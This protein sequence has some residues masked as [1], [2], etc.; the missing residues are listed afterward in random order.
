[1]KKRLLAALLAAGLCSSLVTGCSEDG[2]NTAVGESDG[3]KSLAMEQINNQQLNMLDDNYRT[4]YEVFVYSFYDSDKDGI[5]DLKGLTEKLDYI[6]DG[7]DTT[8]ADLGCNEI[9]LMPIMPSTTYHKYDVTDYC[10]IDPEY[11]TMEDFT[12][13]VEECHKRGVRVIIDFVMN[14]TSSKHEWFTA[15]CQYLQSLGEGEEPDESVCP[16]VG[17]YN[18][19]KESK[20]NYYQVPGT[21]WYYEGQFWS[22]MPDLNL[23]NEAVRQEFSEIVR[24]WLGMGVDGFRLDAVKEYVTGNNSANVEVL[25]WFTDMVKAQKDDAYLVGEAWS[26]YNTYAQYYGSGMDSLFDFAFADKDGYIA[27]VL[28]GSAKSGASTYGKAIAAVDETIRKYTENYINAPFYTNHDLARGAG[29]YT[30]EYAECKVKMGQ[31]MNLLMSGTAFLYYGEEIGMKGAG[32]DENKRLG[33]YWSED[34]DT[35]G[36]CDGPKDADSVKM[37]YDSLEDQQ[38]DSCSI[39]HFVKQ[40]IKIRNIYPE[41]ARGTVTFCEELSDDQVCVL[42]KEYKGSQLLLVFNI[43]GNENTVD[44]SGVSLNGKET[45]E[46]E[47]AATLQTSEEAVSVEGSKVILPAY[48]IEILK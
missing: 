48:S 13:L 30:G 24:F 19:T 39:Y 25:T 45:G 47:A 7:D 40:A 22:E 12:V 38:K 3:V 28:N 46:I 34:P 23:S 2:K 9:W 35:E 4:C 41:I 21:D 1:M 36:M 44:L 11:G 32:K 20:G 37:S 43:S 17:Y 42:M 26:D 27:R 18:F 29:Y 8:D 14:H 10:A 15:A 16:Y 5:G 31:A 6:N 33:M